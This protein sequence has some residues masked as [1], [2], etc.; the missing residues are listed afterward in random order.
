MRIS[1][2]GRY[3]LAAMSY[4]A[5]NYQNGTATTV[6]HI[7]ENLGI[8]KIYLEQVFSLLK[9]AGLV[10]SIKGSQGGYILNNAP[11]EITV[12]D[13]LTAIETSLIEK[14]DTTV[15]EKEPFLDKAMQEVV[16]SQLDDAIKSSLE[17]ITLEDILNNVEKQKEPDNLMYFI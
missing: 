12:Y 16:F 10:I 14:T 3:G 15:G 4:L 17:A 7:S 11:G 1:A 6:M 13:V 9:R 5:A 2:K 8:S